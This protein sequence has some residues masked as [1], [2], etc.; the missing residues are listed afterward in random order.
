MVHLGPMGCL[1]TNMTGWNTTMFNRKFIFIH[2]GFAIVMLVFYDFTLRQYDFMGVVLGHS[3]K[4]IIP[5][6]NMHL[7]IYHKFNHKVKPS[8]GIEY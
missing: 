6:W 3:S 1:K 7:Y 8:V 2:G 4:P 5:L